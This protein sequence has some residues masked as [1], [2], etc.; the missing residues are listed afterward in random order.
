MAL[1]LAG[2]Y[3]REPSNIKLV[4]AW[5]IQKYDIG[6]VGIEYKL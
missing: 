2:D 5:V 3:V 6:Y 4:R 1:E